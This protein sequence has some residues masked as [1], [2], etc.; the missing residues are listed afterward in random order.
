MMFLKSEF[1]IKDQLHIFS[2]E[3][4]NATNQILY[5]K[6]NFLKITFIA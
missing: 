6:K 3:R 5:K 4:V 1:I 2:S